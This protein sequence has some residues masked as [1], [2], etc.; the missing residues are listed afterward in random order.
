M[1]EKWLN[2]KRDE[3]AIFLGLTGLKWGKN[4]VFQVL[5]KTELQKFFDFWHD[6]ATI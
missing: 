4:K 5:L 2:Q 6:I 3:L 1:L